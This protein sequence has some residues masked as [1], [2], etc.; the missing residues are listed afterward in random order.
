VIV[1]VSVLSVFFFFYDEIGPCGQK[2]GYPL[3]GGAGA[4]TAAMASSGSR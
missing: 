1:R 2:P 4:H 3:A